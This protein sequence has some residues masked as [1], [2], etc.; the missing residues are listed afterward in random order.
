MISGN[1]PSNKLAVMQTYEIAKKAKK[2]KQR[3]CKF[4]AKQR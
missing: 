1:L 2:E 3:R 4:D